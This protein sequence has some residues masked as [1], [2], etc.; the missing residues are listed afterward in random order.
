M[1][2]VLI[3]GVPDTHHLWDP[4]LHELRRRDDVVALALPGFAAP[5]PPGFAATKE[6]YVD[7]LID[8]IARFGEPVDVVG[9]DWGGTFVQRLVSIRPDLFRT[10]VAGSGVVHEEYVWHDLARQWQTPG[11]G[12]AVMEGFTPA[13]LAEALAGYGVPRGLADAAAGRVDATMK[14]CILRLYRSAV[15]VGAEWAGDLDRIRRPGLVLWSEGDQFADAAWGQRL[16]ERTGAACHLLPGCG[17]WWPAER[18]AEA[19]R[20][21]DTFWHSER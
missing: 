21:I 17:H 1:P 18:P 12:E 9:H 11:V 19:A 13:A 6:A 2:A 16:A 10:W 15:R 5:L 14:D 3:H 7:W 20:A 8:E 4:L